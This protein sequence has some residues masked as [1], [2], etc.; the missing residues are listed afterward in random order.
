MLPIDSLIIEALVENE[1]ESCI[2]INNLIDDAFN[3]LGDVSKVP[4]NFEGMIS[5]FEN[6]KIILFCLFLESTKADLFDDIKS[7]I[8]MITTCS[9]N[10]AQ[11]SKRSNAKN[12]G[13]NKGSQKS[14][15]KGSNKGSQ[16]SGKKENKIKM[17]NTFIGIPEVMFKIFFV[18][19]VFFYHCN[20]T[21]IVRRCFKI[22]TC[23][24]Y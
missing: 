17:L 15:K 7:K 19:Y 16:K 2:R 5:L 23:K 12:K 24:I 13:S 20:C 1:I 11:H 9:L 8:D 14:G 6:N 18:N 10:T 21:G 3:D 22:Y 4:V